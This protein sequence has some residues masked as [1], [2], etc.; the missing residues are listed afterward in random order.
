[1][2]VAREIPVKWTDILLGLAICAW[3]PVAAAPSEGPEHARENPYG[4]GWEC[5]SGYL[6]VSDTCVSIVVPANGYLDASGSSWRCDRGSLH[7]HHRC[8]AIHVSPKAYLADC[9]SARG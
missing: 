8:V 5:G 7:V 9:V 2:T 3:L 1:M 4:S 6:R